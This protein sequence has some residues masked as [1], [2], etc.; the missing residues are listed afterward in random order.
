MSVSATAVNTEESVVV[1]TP[2]IVRVEALMDR[3]CCAEGEYNSA[4]ID[5]VR[6]HFRSGGKRIRAKLALHAAVRL[7]LEPEDAIAI[8]GCC[9]L[10]R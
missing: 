8:A 2:K 9:E 4:T 1:L 3:L 5:A 10:L 7:A 6:H